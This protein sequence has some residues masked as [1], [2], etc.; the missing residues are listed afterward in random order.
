MLTGMRGSVLTTLVPI[1]FTQ[2]SSS[3]DG[4]FV[5]SASHGLHYSYICTTLRDLI[6]MCRFRM[7]AHVFER[8]VEA[9]EAA[10]SYFKQK[11]DAIGR[12]GRHQP[13]G[14]DAPSPSP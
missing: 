2:R 7:R 9:I 3:V 14:N 1:L 10:D 11:E 6:F 4:V 13:A 5:E 8:L 12:P